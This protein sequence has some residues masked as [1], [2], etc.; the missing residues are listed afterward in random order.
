MMEL[1]I[2]RAR[3]V[4]VSIHLESSSRLRNYITPPTPEMV[5]DILHGCRIANLIM[6]IT[7]SVQNCV[8]MLRSCTQIVRCSFT[9]I[10]LFSEYPQPTNIEPIPLFDLQ[11]LRLRTNG[12]IGPLFS[13]FKLPALANLSVEY[14]SSLGDNLWPQSEFATLISR[15]ACPLQG[16]HLRGITM[17][18]AELIACLHC[19]NSITEISIV[20]AGRC[21]NDFVLAAMTFR[22]NEGTPLNPRLE[23]VHFYGH[24]YSDQAV[25]DM[26]ES[27]WRHSTSAIF[28]TAAQ[29]ACLKTVRVVLH[30]TSGDPWQ[31]LQRFHREGL[32]TMGSDVDVLPS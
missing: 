14:T 17:P 20:D 18:S 8:E 2:S 26:V 16:L 31:R 27:R 9:R 30:V 22:S 21:L 29:V 12:D 1:W 19:V 3:A 4:P 24:A 28:Q 7:L 6:D 5:V 13:Q 15:S 11:S 23:K 25:V 32:D 10:T